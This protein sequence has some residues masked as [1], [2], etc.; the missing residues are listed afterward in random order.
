[1]LK[2]TQEGLLEELNASEARLRP[3]LDTY[4]KDLLRICGPAYGGNIDFVLG[5]PENHWQEWLSIFLPQLVYGNP[6]CSV[7]PDNIAW[8]PERAK[9]VEASLNT[10]GRITDIR[11]E[12][13]RLAT[14]FAV[15]WCCGIVQPQPVV[16]H[17][18]AEDPHYLPGFARL[19]PLDVR[20][21]PTTKDIRKGR[22]TA[23]RVVHDID[24]LIERVKK[25]EAT[26]WDLPALEVHAKSAGGDARNQKRKPG[27]SVER[28]QL[29]VWE[30]WARGHKLEGAPGEK[31]GYHGTLFTVLDGQH[32]TSAT[33]EFIRKPR[34]FFGRR[35][36]PHIIQGAML[37]GDLCE[38]LS[39][40]VATTPQ[41]VYLNKVARA[42]QTAVEDYKR[43]TVTTD[44]NLADKMANGMDGSV[45]T[46]EGIDIRQVV[47]T[48]EMGGLNQQLLAA[49]EDARQ[50]LDRN[51]GLHEAQRGNVT[52]VATATE[53]QAANMSSQLRSSFLVQ[54]FRDFVREVYECA[55]FY[56]DLDPDVVLDLGDGMSTR[57]GIPRSKKDKWNALDHERLALDIDPYSMGRTDEQ[58]KQMR[59]AACNAAIQQVASLPPDV[60]PSFN[61][62]WYLGVVQE[63]SGLRDID[64]MFDPEVYYQLAAMALQSE[65]VIQP[66]P[67]KSGSPRFLWNS[68]SYANPGASPGGSRAAGGKPAQTMKLAA[69]KPAGK[70]PSVKPVSSAK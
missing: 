20:W 10:W 6:H 8:V 50:T 28:R 9:A 23:H 32:A 37:I 11:H 25:G 13:E 3:F 12:I 1:M 44:P 60:R 26:G 52:G 30:L 34:A 48:I 4:E 66:A 62:L 70:A 19:S 5:D 58:T 35:K 17:D 47:Q 7:S 29:V 53:V 65:Q 43:G 42:V 39:Q 61:L 33:K 15:R 38:P 16:G 18:G 63:A 46:V 27:F 36:G 14:D 45:W 64:R 54:K 22:W 24:D 2:Y 68:S 67:K 55:G 51:S 49:K 56:F 69:P 57:G 21:D 40:L 59:L 31:K 41:A